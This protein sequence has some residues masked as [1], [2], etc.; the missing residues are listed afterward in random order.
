MTTETKSTKV[1]SYE[2]ACEIL[3]QDPNDLPGV[4][5][6]PEKHRKYYTDQHKLITIIEAQNKISEETPEWKIDFSEDNDQ[7]K[8]YPWPEVVK[9]E[10][11]SG[12]GL[13]LYAVY[14]SSSFSHVGSRLYL[15]SESDAKY[16]FEKFKDLYESFHLY[17]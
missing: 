7:L 11:K 15:G 10:S 1:E 13:S 3:G 14:Y 16:V 6:L 12:L 9:D 17:K 8:Y 5:N 2:H 4:Y